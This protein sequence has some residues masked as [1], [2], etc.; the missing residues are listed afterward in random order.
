MAMSGHLGLIGEATLE[1]EPR[2]RFGN[3]VYG[4]FGRDFGTRDG[5]R[6]MVLA[7]TG[8]QWLSLGEATG[9][10]S[11]FSELESRIGADFR[12]EGDR[13]RHRR[14][15]CQLL[16]Q[17]IAQRDLAEVRDVFDQH[18]VLWGP[19][20][21]VKQMVAEDPRVSTANPMFSEVDHPGLGRFLTAGSPLRFGRAASAPARPAPTLG[22]HTAEVL[23]EF[24]L[25]GPTD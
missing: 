12:R 8:R 6:V 7:L 9:L 23:R 5:R 1:P 18:Q 13:W 16:E 17:W 19:Y 24:G 2:G 22:Q 14:Q 3:D 10:S 20:Q 25:S 4:T 21:T 11:Q 15:L